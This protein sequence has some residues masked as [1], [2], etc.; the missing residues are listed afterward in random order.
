MCSV[1]HFMNRISFS[2]DSEIQMKNILLSSKVPQ[3]LVNIFFNTNFIL[4]DT[5]TLTFRDAFTEGV[6]FGLFGVFW[7]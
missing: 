7:L 4:T 1:N 6:G 3:F 5:Q 2:E